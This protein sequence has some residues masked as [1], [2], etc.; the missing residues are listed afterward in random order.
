MDYGAEWRACRKLEHIALGP[1]TMRQ[2]EPMQEKFSA[3]LAKD[4]L[5]T[6]DEFFELIRLYVFLTLQASLLIST[7]SCAARIVLA[8]TY[9][10][11]APIL[12]KEVRLGAVLRYC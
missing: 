2:Y 10:L 8:L 1:A 3:T 5:E 6:P 7:C 9:G 12:D 4:I 11:S